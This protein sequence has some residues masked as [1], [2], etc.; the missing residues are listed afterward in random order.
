VTTVRAAVILLRDDKP[1]SQFAADGDQPLTI[2][3]SADNI[4]Q[5]HDSKI[6]R[7]HC[8]I[9]CTPGGYFVRDLGSKNGTFVNGARVA[10]A[11]LRNNDRLQLGLAQLLFRCEGDEAQ[12]P[13]TAPPH[14]CASC[15]KIIPLDAIATA[16][17][18]ESRVYCAACVAASPL[19]G[20]IIGR[21]EIIQ[22]LGVGPIG[23]VFKADQLSMGRLVALKIIHDSLA[24]E[25]DAISRF[26]RDAR[27]SGHL[28]HPNIIRIYDMNQGDGRYFISMEYAQGGELG[29]LLQRQGPLP[30]RDVVAFASAACSALA[31]AHGAGVVHGSLKPTN[32]LFTRD[33]ILKVADFGLARSLDV[34]GLSSLTTTS[35]NLETVHYLAP[36]RILANAPPSVQSDIY[37]LGVT[38]YRLLTGHF[39]FQAESVGELPSAFATQKPRTVRSFRPDCP[40]ELDAAIAR[41]I[42]VDP[43]LRFAS[44]DEMGRALAAVGR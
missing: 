16:R 4:I 30:V 18:T 5:I 40:Q 24:A 9:R 41:A 21:Y 44:A 38:C 6:S 1:V 26:L 32:L 42:E 10:E 12:E 43:A 28:S 36:D 37:A 22:L 29:S 13:Q 11:R 27:T 33:G 23:S 20:Q 31:Y 2:G 15:G 17:H 34:A 14:L 25:P 19:L 7:H 3:R 8:E 39:P 35:T